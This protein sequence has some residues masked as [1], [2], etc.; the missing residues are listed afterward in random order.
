M[1]SS[2]FIKWTPVVDCDKVPA[3]ETAVRAQMAAILD[4]YHSHDDYED[5]GVDRFFWALGVITDRS[6]T[7]G[8]T[9]L[10]QITEEKLCGS[11]KRISYLL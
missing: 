6:D 11:S 3:G 4:H 10:S 2:Q 8:S 1:A 7:L 9:F 5:C